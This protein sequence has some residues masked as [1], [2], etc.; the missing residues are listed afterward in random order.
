VAEIIFTFK[1]GGATTVKVEGVAG[2]KCRALSKPFIE[3]LAGRTVSDEPTDEM[4]ETETEKERDFE[5]E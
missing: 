1:P 4:Y 3:A 2:D 5:T